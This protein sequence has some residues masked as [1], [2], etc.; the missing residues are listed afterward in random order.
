MYFALAALLFLAFVGNVVSGSIDG[1][2]ILNNVQEMLLLFGAA[3]SFSA[4]ILVA[5][6]KAKSKKQET[7]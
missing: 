7:E 6:E 1:S 4:A 3:I 5:E 2:A